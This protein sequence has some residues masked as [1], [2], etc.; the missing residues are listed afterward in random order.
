MVAACTNPAALAGG[1]GELHAYFVNRPTSV[2]VTP[3]KPIATPFVSLPGLLTATCS[4]NQFASGFLEVT[5]HG[6]PSDARTDDLPPTSAL[7]GTTAA[8]WGLHQ[9]DVTLTI[10][11][12][13][14]VV[15]QQARAYGN[16]MGPSPTP[17]AT[18]RRPN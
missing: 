8:M 10:G 2:W 6:D 12:L 18:R 11:N 9:L 7:G 16:R 3:P 13:I 1:S 4:S 14:D 5:V 17:C 15:R